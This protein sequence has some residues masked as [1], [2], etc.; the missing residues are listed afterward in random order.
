MS[1][2]FSP[3]CRELDQF[4]DPPASVQCYDPTVSTSPMPEYNITPERQAE[5]EELSAAVMEQNLRTQ[6]M[7]WLYETSGRSS[8]HY[9]GLWQEFKALCLEEY[10]QKMAEEA[11]SSWGETNCKA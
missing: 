3:T 8:G 10:T 1:H 2:D 5:A 6:F 4:V 9:T 7:D 11:R